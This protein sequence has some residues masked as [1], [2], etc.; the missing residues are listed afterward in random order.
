MNDIIQRLVKAFVHRHKAKT[1]GSTGRRPP[2]VA[3]RMRR[4]MKARIRYRRDKFKIRAKRRIYDK[5]RRRLHLTRK[6]AGRKH[7]SFLSHIHVHHTP[8]AP[9]HHG[10]RLKSTGHRRSYVMK[11]P[12]AHV[13]PRL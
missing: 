1:F 13:S 3:Q 12:R 4:R 6:H 11:K 7:P 2:T 8:H 5:K 9:L 10:V